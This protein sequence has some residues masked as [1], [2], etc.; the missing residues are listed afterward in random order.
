MSWLILPGTILTLLGLAALG[1]CIVTAYK[2]SK[3]GAEPDAA[4]TKLQKLVAVNF[5]GVA[6]SALGLM[7]VVI[8]L[9][10]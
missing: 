7:M 5:A 9:L 2:I 4:R 3:S 10:I 1:Y 8:G 6:L